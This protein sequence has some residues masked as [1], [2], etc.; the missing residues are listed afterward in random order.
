MSRH[1]TAEH[2]AALEK[3]IHRLRANGRSWEQV[4]RKTG[5][6]VGQARYIAYDRINRPTRPAPRDTEG[7]RVYMQRRRATLREQGTSQ[8]QRF[9][10]R[11]HLITQAKNTNRDPLE[12]L[13]Q[14]NLAN[15]QE[16]RVYNA[17][18]KINT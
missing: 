6:S 13:V 11:N 10:L 4:A 16:R 5:L 18:Q 9:T 17:V 15:E 3:I 8:F 7:E 12:V 2:Y 1:T 14:E